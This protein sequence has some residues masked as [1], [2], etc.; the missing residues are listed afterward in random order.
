[1]AKK[2]AQ[3]RPLYRQKEKFAEIMSRF[4]VDAR[5]FDGW[6]GTAAGAKLRT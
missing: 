4:S 5:H 3:G 2:S 1:M 6:T